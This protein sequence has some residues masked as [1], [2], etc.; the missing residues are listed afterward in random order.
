MEA[1]PIVLLNQATGKT[2]AFACGKCHVVASSP[3]GFIGTEDERIAAARA[4]AMEHC[5]PWFCG[6]GAERRQ[7]WETCEPCL[8]KRQAEAAAAKERAAFERAEKVSAKDWTGEFVWSERLE[9]LFDSIDE[10]RGRYEDVDEEPPEYVWECEEEALTLDAVQVIEDALER[11]EASG[12]RIPDGA[13]AELQA[14]LDGWLKKHPVRW[15]REAH[16][17]AV[18]LREEER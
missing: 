14:L 5:G 18:V 6:C 15:W 8:Y 1:E 11:Q 10:L 7:H 3:K 12:A 2:A 16:R 4:A 17:R 9:E 13:T